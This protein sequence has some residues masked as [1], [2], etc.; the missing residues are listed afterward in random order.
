MK[1]VLTR[2]QPTFKRSARQPGPHWRASTG[3]SRRGFLVSGVGMASIGLPPLLAGCGGSD[4]DNTTVQPAPP[5]TEL[6]TLFF[7]LAHEDHAGKT[8]YLT[9]GGH[10]YALT[11]VSDAP[12]VLQRERQTNLFLSAVPDDQITHHVENA[13]FAADSVTLAY[14]GAEI[15]AQAGT[16]S[17]SSVQLLI[18]TSGAA[19]AYA[20]ARLAM[21]SG[22]L[23][24]SAKRRFYGFPA[25][26][27][28]RD[29][30]EERALLDPASHAATIVGC[31]PDLMS[32]EPNSAHTVQSNHVERSIDVLLLANKLRQPQYGPAL[33]QQTPGQP[34][35][36]GWATLQPVPGDGGAPLKNQNG[37]HKGRIQYQPSTHA[38]LRTLAASAMNGTIPGVKDDASLG[39]DITGLK[40]GP[41]DAPAAIPNLALGGALW[42][43]RDGLT[44]IDRSAGATAAAGA[45]VGDDNAAMALK[46]QNPQSGYSVSASSTQG[47]V[48]TTASL[49]IVN[50][51]LEFRGLWLQFLDANGKVLPLAN[52]PEYTSGSIVPSHDKSQDTATD[53]FVSIVGPVF[54]VLA[55]PVAPGFLQ[56]SFKVPASAS[57]VRI[58]SSGLSYQGGNTYP[59]S[60]LHGA[61]MT[62]VFNYGVTALLCAAGG[63]PFIPA[64]W[65]AIVIPFAKVL[66]AELITIIDTSLN[67][68]GNKSLVGQLITPGFWEAQALIVAR[69][70]VSSAASGAV[71]E[72]V[73]YIAAQLAEG[74]AEDAIPIAG[75][76]MQAISIVA[77]V[78]SLA[79]TSAELATTPWTYVD[80]LV[81]THDL[82]VTILKDSGNPGATPPDPGSATFPATATSYSVTAM[83]DDGTPYV[84]TFPLTAPILS[85]LPPVVFKGVP[86]GGK[87]NVSVAFV[88]KAIVPGQL[89]IL[90]GKGTT[91]PIANVAGSAP[92]FAIEELKFP[93]SA[94][95]VYRHTQKITLDASGNHVWAAASAPTANAGN[96]VCGAAGTLCGFRGISVRQGTGSARGYLGYAWQGQNS[97][98]GRAPS[99]VGAG[100]G[101]LD[102][103]AN[104]NTDSGNG[105]ANAQTGYVNGAC[106]IGVP[107]VRVAYSLLSDGAANF[108][109]DTTNPDVPTVRQVVLEPAPAF[110]SP[111]SGQAWGVL[112]LPSDS[113]LLHP[114]GHLVS[115]NNTSHKIE[116]HKIPATA[117]ADADARVQL[118]AQIKSGKG[119]RPG[120]INSPV[121]CAISPDGVILVLEV[122]NNRIQAFDLG[123]NP[124]RHFSKQTSPYSLTLSATDP[125]QGW[126]YLDLAVEFTGYMYVLA[127][128]QNTFVY[129]LDL[130]HPEQ[131][132]N[133]PIAT[134]Q[135]INAARVTVDFWRSVYTLNYEV[136]SLPGGAAAGLTEPSVSLWTPCDTGST[137]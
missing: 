57:T 114:A 81:F 25:A 38:D 86:L 45:G 28:E 118:L 31:H 61:I 35:A 71:R 137:C 39:A 56:P 7:N 52:I 83:F 103:V 26:E 34:N 125:M 124:V 54:T 120:L 8:Y 17:M 101:Q 94:N 97:D 111:L 19:Y 72:L 127:Y 74:V 129:R 75:Q 87:V 42:M 14:V 89:D 43:R 77:G 23:P 30:R 133:T 99:C 115:I 106:G 27:S 78:A 44:R 128:N 37:L 18:P 62:G 20:R 55:I 49:S 104:L 91:G 126:Q 33:P 112:N 110:A 117:M 88:Q 82:S 53:M 9:G 46:Q 41:N 123:A 70:L 98:P 4:Q 121:A 60:V 40:I 24:P 95:T 64:L 21:P 3:V 119:S 6:R 63:G 1:R 2:K 22:A 66:V 132:D 5:A 108:Y 134:T 100:V 16:W 92:S 13:L 105:G 90:L 113:L 130:Y 116:T 84:Q 96:A 59:D 136:L 48:A 131:A 85:T 32:L 79:E 93:I 11:R 76:I 65:K 36:S 10:R 67:P 80:D 122:G 29:L 58:L 102:Q 107:G 69:T 15:D 68:N 135:N 50:W 51:Y 12:H 47:G 73:A 109:L